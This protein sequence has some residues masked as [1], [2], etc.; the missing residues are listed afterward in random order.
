M[1]ARKK[2]TRAQVE[3]LKK[4]MLPP[5]DSVATEPKKPVRKTA[6]TEKPK[7]SAQIQGKVITYGSL[8]H[9][10]VPTDE[11]KVKIPRHV[12]E[13]IREHAEPGARSTMIYAWLLE[14]GLEAMK[15]ELERGDCEIK[16]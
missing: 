10:T 9:K 6:R 12:S 11:R 13:F 15:A 8:H 2:A 14:R 3:A 4:E 5:A 16:F 7:E 1:T